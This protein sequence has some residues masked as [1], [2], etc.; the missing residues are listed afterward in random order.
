MKVIFLENNGKN[1]I[2]EIKDIAAG[3]AVNFLIPKGIAL[4][5]TKENL[6]KLAQNKKNAMLAEEQM[7][8]DLDTLIQK[9]ESKKVVISRK[10][11]PHG[12]LI[13]SVTKSDIASEFY[14][15]TGIKIDKK[16]LRMDKI[17]SFFG[18]CDISLYLGHGKT[19]T[20]KVSIVKEF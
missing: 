14:I 16:E 15:Q 20:I 4:E 8:A 13:G 10:A 12:L 11:S 17:H 18:N 1:K 2:G 7:L 3:H 9:I 19:A 5:A 6:H